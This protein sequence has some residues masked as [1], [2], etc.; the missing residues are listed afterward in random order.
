MRGLR[1]GQRLAAA[2]LLALATLPA[3][4]Q[5]WPAKPVRVVVPYPPGGPV[6]ISARLLAPKLQEA[7]GQP[8]VVENKPGAG[9]NIGADFVAKSAPDGYTI[10][11][12]A[13]AT[14]AINPAL[15][16]NVPY[17]PIKDFR[18]LALV[19]QVPNVL[20]VNTELPVKSVPELI[21]YAKARPGRLDFASGSTGSTGH[22]AGELFKQMTGTFM[23][24]IP[25]KGAPAAVAD[26]LAG[27]VHLMFDN[28]SS[29][30]PNVKSGHVRALAVTTL[31]RSASLPDLP[32]LDE[33]GL[34]GF[35]M[36][37][38][39]GLMGP[40]G[41][42]P[43]VVQRLSAA[44]LNG[45]DAPDVKER[46]RAMGMEGS[47]VRTPEQFTAFVDAERRLYAKLVKQS[48]AKPD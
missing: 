10:G 8:F 1:I 27:R 48:G 29:A 46:L 23:V 34:K 11:M 6:D 30:L 18:H 33:S 31:K 15:M 24:H 19:V 22:L 42:S 44:I 41:M 13:I 21:A 2:A 38:W 39:W 20:I 40:A 14:H 25:Y 3:H 32:T 28:L 5:A 4:G 36:T 37:T 9:G 12:G 7:L 17:D 16:A 45:M 47:A 35:D 26:L 43:D